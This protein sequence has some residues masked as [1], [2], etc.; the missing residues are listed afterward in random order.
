[1]SETA[2]KSITLWIPQLLHSS[3]IKEAQEQLKI[4][5][6]P[7]L[8]RLLAKADSLPMKANQSFYQT[9]S[10]LFHQPA[11]LPI[12][13][14]LAMAELYD[15]DE[16]LFWLKI[17]PVQLIADR[18]SLVLVP[19]KDLGITEA[20]SQALLEAFN[21]HFA[22]DSVQLAY[23]SPTSWYLSIVQSV[24]IQTVSIEDLSYK[25]LNDAMPKG[26]AATYWKKLINETQML[27]FSHPVNEARREKNMPEINSI[28]PWGEGM[29]AEDKI[30]FREQASI[31]SNN[32]YLKGIAYKTTPTPCFQL[33]SAQGGSL[34][35][36][37]ESNT[38]HDLICLDNIS[39][40]LEQLSEQQWLDCLLQLDKDYFEPLY[41]QLKQGKINSLLL[42][43]GLNERYHLVPKHLNRF[44]RLNKQIHKYK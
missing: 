11:T 42:D 37:L 39:D 38:E 36:A 24:D 23:A 43:L 4:I 34:K 14:T 8:S 3:R 12:A 10:Y 16:H 7:W 19:A 31:H 28:W 41:Q 13:A 44:W 40:S 25:P 9:A 20:E 21:Q 18:D 26:N 27:F 5:K 2:T 33:K 29:F 35:Q 32:L 1:M 22:E 30:K 15:A 17:D 6:L